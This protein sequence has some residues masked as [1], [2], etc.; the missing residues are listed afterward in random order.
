MVKVVFLPGLDG[1]GALF[2]AALLDMPGVT[3][4]PMAL[5]DVGDRG[6]EGLATEI[7]S[8]LPD[9]DLVLVA[10]SFSGPIAALIAA[11]LG[12]RIRG[13]VFVATF[14][15]PPN[16]FLLGMAQI[17]PLRGLLTLFPVQAIARTLLFGRLS[18]RQIFDRFLEVVAAMPAGRI[19]ERLRAVGCIPRMAGPIEVPVL[20]I[21]AARDWL[22]PAG[23]GEE[24]S[25]YFP[26]LRSVTV[27]G[28]HFLLQARPEECRRL[29]AAFLE[30]V[31]DAGQGA[32]HR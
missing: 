16:R 18:D 11:R 6:Y 5:P 8:E 30:V 17:L 24:F 1:T 21:R 23:K 20:Y 31:G 3:A 13:V 25:V 2:P 15:T 27:D 14:L 19:R 29:I 22:V 32:G 7:V 9:G 10:E 4:L 28:P 12:S 26:H